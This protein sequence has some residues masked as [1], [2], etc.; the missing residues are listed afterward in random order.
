[1]DAGCF[2]AIYIEASESHGK[3]AESGDFRNLLSGAERVAGVC[4]RSLPLTKR[5][6]AIADKP[7]ARR[8]RDERQETEAWPEQQGRQEAAGG[9]AP[10]A[11][12]LHPVVQRR[13]RAPS[14]LASGSRCQCRASAPL[15]MQAI[16]GIASAAASGGA[17]RTTAASAVALSANGQDQGNCAASP[18]AAVLHDRQRMVAIASTTQAVRTIRQTVLVRAPVNA[19][20]TA[21]A[22]KADISRSAWRQ[23]MTRKTSPGRTANDGAS[24]RKSPARPYRACR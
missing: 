11:S 17:A 14:G 4:R 18:D 16:A 15:L 6:K 13:R 3:G 9:E 24:D 10:Y 8:A 7:Q 20:R 19:A 23:S 22:A 2:H 21:S 12:R 5:V 1:M